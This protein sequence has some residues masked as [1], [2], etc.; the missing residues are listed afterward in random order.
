MDYPICTFL[1]WQKAHPSNQS[2][3]RTISSD[4]HF[5][6]CVPSPY[7]V[8]H[9]VVWTGT[10]GSRRRAIPLVNVALPQDKSSQ[11]VFSYLDSVGERAE[12]AVYVAPGSMWRP[13]RSEA[14]RRLFCDREVQVFRA[15]AGLRPVVESGV[16]AF[17]RSRA[18][19][20]FL[21]VH[22]I[23]PAPAP[24]TLNRSFS[25]TVSVHSPLCRLS[26]PCDRRLDLHRR[27]KP[28]HLPQPRH[29]LH[30]TLPGR[31]LREGQHEHVR[32][33]HLV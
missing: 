11:I 32:G 24:C 1:C 10:V 28:G 3:A 13:S 31:Q 14:C 12:V 30:R 33:Y 26:S 15:N 25:I 21:P 29:G 18:T 4:N 19:S 6:L 20:L 16:H 22:A 9:V 27:S 17:K 5:C 7:T 8:E 2:A 23:A